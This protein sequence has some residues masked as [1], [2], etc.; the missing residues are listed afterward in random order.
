M[1]GIPQGPEPRNIKLTLALTDSEKRAVQGFANVRGVTETDIVRE[2][3]NFAELVEA[4]ENA[5][6]KLAEVA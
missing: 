6:A 4:W 5:R 1:A 2:R 3:I